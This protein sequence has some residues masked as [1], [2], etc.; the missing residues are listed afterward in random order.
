MP[1]V[2]FIHGI[3]NKPDQDKLLEIWLHALAAD[4]N[5]LALGSEGVT[6]TMVYWADVLYEKPDGNVAA[7]ESAGLY[8]SI[9]ADVTLTDKDVDMAWREEITGQEKSGPTHLRQSWPLTLWSTM[10]PSH[11]SPKSAPNLNAFLFPGG[12]SDA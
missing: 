3:A 6:S 5:P 9:G 11:R 10:T 1:H 8:E 4:T 2:T 12:S 7:Y